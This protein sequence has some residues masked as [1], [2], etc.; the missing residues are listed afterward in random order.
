MHFPIIE[1]KNISLLQSIGI[2]PVPQDY[3]SLQ[4]INHLHIVVKV[5]WIF[6]D[7]GDHYID[8]QFILINTLF[9][10]QLII[11]P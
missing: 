10:K 8:R 3:G 9:L 6:F 11:P 1:N 5:D 4:N 7:I 2:I